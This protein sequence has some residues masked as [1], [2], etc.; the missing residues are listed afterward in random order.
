[1]DLLRLAVEIA[2]LDR[3]VLAFA[4]VGREFEGVAVCEVKRFVNIED[5]LHPVVAGGDVV[6]A[7]GRIAERGGVNDGGGS[8]VE[9]F[10][11]DAEYLL[12]VGRHEA[13][14]E[15]RFLFVV[16]GDQEQD[17][18]VERRAA[19]FFGEGNFEARG[20][21]G[22]GLGGGGMGGGRAQ[23]ECD[24]EISIEH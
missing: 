12:G 24:G 4:F 19:H 23:D 8:R 11:V 5:G 21:L 16:V 1:V 13:D 10:D 9:R 6:E 22:G 3:P 17:V 14:L 20:R 2:R 7:F 15:A 18:A